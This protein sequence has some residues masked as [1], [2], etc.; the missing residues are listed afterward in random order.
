MYLYALTVVANFLHTRV[1]KAKD[2]GATATE[3]ALLVAFIAA[4]I[5]VVISLFGQDLKDFF[6][7]L[8]TKI[9]IGDTHSTSGS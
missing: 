7:G 9:G 8:A 1:E 6:S 4:A 3:Y 5:A 2:R